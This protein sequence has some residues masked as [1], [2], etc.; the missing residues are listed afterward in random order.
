MESLTK[1]RELG[2]KSHWYPEGVPFLEYFISQ[3]YGTR[4]EK[5]AIK[6]LPT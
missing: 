5:L 4:P 6:Y 3:R 2:V 1:L